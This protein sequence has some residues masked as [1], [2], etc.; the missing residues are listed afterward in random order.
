MPDNANQTAQ[1]HVGIFGIV[2]AGD[3]TGEVDVFERSTI[4]ITEGCHGDVRMTAASASAVNGNV[5]GVA[6]A[7]KG[8]TEGRV[9][10]TRHSAYGDVGP[11]FEKLAAVGV[12]VVD[13]AGEEVP[14]L[15][16]IDEIGIGSGAFS[17]NIGSPP[18]GVERGIGVGGIGGAGAVGGASAVGGGSPAQEVVAGVGRNGAA[19]GEVNT[20]VLHLLCWSTAAAVGIEGDGIGGLDS[21]LH[22][23]TIPH[24]VGI[25]SVIV[26]IDGHL[27]SSCH[28]NGYIVVEAVVMPLVILTKAFAVCRQAYRAALN[29]ILLGIQDKYFHSKWGAGGIL[30]FTPSLNVEGSTLSFASF[31]RDSR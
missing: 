20:V 19:E 18:L 26:G 10:G 1:R 14:M 3:R 7:D 28:G 6:V 16:A 13:V 27:V 29:M 9:V 31:N 5:H 25:A 8:A 15:R 21:N 2:I 22:Q 11:Q 17:R 4:D 12:T 23:V 30:V 24:G